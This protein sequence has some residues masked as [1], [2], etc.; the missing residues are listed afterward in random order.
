MSGPV[1]RPHEVTLRLNVLKLHII[2]QGNAISFTMKFI[3]QFVK[4]SPRPSGALSGILSMGRSATQM[5]E[6]STI[7]QS[8]VNGTDAVLFLLQSVVD[9]YQSYIYSNLYFSFVNC[10]FL[11]NVLL[12]FKAVLQMTEPFTPD[13]SQ[14]LQF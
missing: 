10:C 7:G 1:T 6:L 3:T 14:T 13:A 12:R 11:L 2:F 4:L 5:L 8:A 9:L